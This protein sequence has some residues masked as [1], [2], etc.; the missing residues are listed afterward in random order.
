MSLDFIRVKNLYI[1]RSNIAAIAVPGDDTDEPE[2]DGLGDEPALV[3]YLSHP[4]GRRQM[5]RLTGEHIPPVLAWVEQ[6]GFHD[7]RPGQQGTP[8]S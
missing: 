1:H 4:L 7:L 5:V 6:G 2:P 3:I 8:G